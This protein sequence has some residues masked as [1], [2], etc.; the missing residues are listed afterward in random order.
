MAAIA[1]DQ[2]IITKYILETHLL[3]WLEAFLVDRKAQNL[4]AGTVIFYC[5]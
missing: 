5:Q 1:Q 4:S 2:G 3:T